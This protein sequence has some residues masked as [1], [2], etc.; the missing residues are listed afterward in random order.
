MLILATESDFTTSL[1]KALKEIDLNWESY[2]GL[3]I[4][5]SHTPVNIE[6]K[7]QKIKEARWSKKPFLGI[8]LGFQL[9]IIEYARTALGKFKANS[10]EIDPQTNYPIIVKLNDPPGYNNEIVR[11]VGIKPTMDLWGKQQMESF[12]HNY[13]MN[14]E[15]ISE[16]VQDWKFLQSY[17]PDLGEYVIDFLL[18]KPMAEKNIFFGGCQYH[19]EYQSSKQKPHWI[20]ENFL[21]SCRLAGRQ[22]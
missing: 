16:Y 2:P 14:N 1:V 12:W 21:Q 4:A 5:G 18:Y 20:L 11:R 6:E 19:P 9:M 15:Y 3:I 13:K 7:I 17:D 8:C 10:T 22:V